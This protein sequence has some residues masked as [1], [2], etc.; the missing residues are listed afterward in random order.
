MKTLKPKNL[1]NKTESLNIP[2]AMLIHKEESLEEIPLEKTTEDII[3]INQSYEQRGSFEF[4]NAFKGSKKTLLEKFFT[5]MNSVETSDDYK[6]RSPLKNLVNKSIECL[7]K[8]REPNELKNSIKL[9][10]IARPSS[11]TPRTNSTKHENDK[12]NPHE[13]KFITG[14]SVKNKLQELKRKNIMVGSRF[15]KKIDDFFV[16][17]LMEKFTKESNHIK[18]IKN[19]NI[20]GYIERK[21]EYISINKDNWI[22]EIIKTLENSKFL[23]MDYENDALVETKREALIEYL[24]QEKNINPL[25]LKVE[26]MELSLRKT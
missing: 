6:E 21:R 7:N 13:F 9:K 24:S 4:N 11:T 12:K 17:M 14:L 18:K 19:S 25:I 15:Y 23:H 3:S 20:E 22:K 10:N 16:E 2:P 1:H 26:Q 8:K 5:K